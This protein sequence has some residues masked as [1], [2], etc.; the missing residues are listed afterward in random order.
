MSLLN[1][2]CVP[3]RERMPRL[4]MELAVGIGNVLVRP[5]SLIL[6]P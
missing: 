6:L 4:A 3:I 1:E 2:I 5:E